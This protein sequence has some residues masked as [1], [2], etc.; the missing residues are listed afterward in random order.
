[1]E[2]GERRDITSMV[3]SED[4]N[5]VLHVTLSLEYMLITTVFVT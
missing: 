1:M 3:V 2:N 4:K 5:V